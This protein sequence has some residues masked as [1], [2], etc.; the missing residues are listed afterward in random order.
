MVERM[1]SLASFHQSEING[2]ESQGVCIK[3]KDEGSMDSEK[4][5]YY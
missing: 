3:Y 4:G 2:G 5:D 1:R